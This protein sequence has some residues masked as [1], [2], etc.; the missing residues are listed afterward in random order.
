MGERRVGRARL[1]LSSIGAAICILGFSQGTVKAAE[2][3]F[4]ITASVQDQSV[5]GSTTSRAPVAGVTIVVTNQAGTE[6]TRGETGTD[7]TIALPVPA[8]DYYVVTLDVSTLPDGVSLIN[9]EKFTAVIE[10]DAFT[11]NDKLV[12]FF[13]G[14]SASSSTS[15]F[16]KILQ[17]SVDG[18][19]L[20][21]IIAICSVGLSLI[22][23]T[24]GL[25]NFAHG[26]MVTFGGL[27]AFWLNVIIGIP[28]LIGAPLVIVLG[29]LFGFLFNELIFGRLRKRGIG[30]ISQLVVSVGLS[31]MLRN[32]YLYQFGGRTRPLDD[33]SLQVAKKFGPVSITMRDLTT[34]IISLVV[35]IAVAMFLQRSRTGK[36]I[37]AV[38]DN[39]ALA[40]STGIDT[41]RI[42]RIVWI[43]GGALAALGGVFRGLD[44]QVGFEMGSGLI[45]LMFAGITLGGL[46]SAYGALV[47]GFFVGLFVELASLV[48]PAELKN[49]PALFILVVVLIV[50]PQG[51]LGR[52]QRVG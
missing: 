5:D 26:E 43:A 17:R 41:Q 33:F 11:T 10:K 49:A 35:L 22:F 18:V 6:V 29:G 38:S 14:A 30:L 9:E 52:K 13:T 50:R 4:T 39:S 32:F 19:R 47:G 21:L 42:I 45:F 48:V 36:A 12:R 27:M 15:L 44:E 37:R 2:S 16:D 3:E 8:K 34:A 51:I 31:I 40:S 23:G 25:T 7:G 1:W 28:L 46:G 20:G 24:T